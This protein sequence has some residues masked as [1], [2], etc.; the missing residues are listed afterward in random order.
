MTPPEALYYILLGMF[1]GMTG[2]M[3]RVIIGVKKVQEKAVSEGR[4]FKEAFDMKRLVIS[5][6][7]GATAGVLGIV[8]LYWGEQEIT[9]EMALG[10]IAIGYS[11][12]DFIEG[13]FRTKVQPMRKEKS[14]PSSTPQS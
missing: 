14:T 6:L 12:T 13:L 4:E 1:L 7:I 9:R 8:S 2:Q 10:L 5:M 11:G 3:I